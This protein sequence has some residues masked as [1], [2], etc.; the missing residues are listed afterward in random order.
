MWLKKMHIAVVEKDISSIDKLIY[1]IPTFT[2]VDDMKFASSLLD[3]A[4]KL[5]HSLKDD[6][7]KTLEKLKK[8]K[9]FLDAVHLDEGLK[10]KRLN[11]SS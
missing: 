9:K 2:T 6:T 1:N 11:V 4:L 8:H 3:E 5:M 10:A 7:G